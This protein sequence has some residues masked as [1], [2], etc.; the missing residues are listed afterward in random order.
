MYP[1]HKIKNVQHRKTQQREDIR[2]TPA[3]VGKPAY[4]FMYEYPKLFG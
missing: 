1:E 4:I 3:E 2:Y